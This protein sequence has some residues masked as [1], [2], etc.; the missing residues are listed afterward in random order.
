MSVV[1]V[2]PEQ[3]TDCRPH[4]THRKQGRA[5]MSVLTGPG[6]HEPCSGVRVDRLPRRVGE[7]SR[8]QHRARTPVPT[9][10]AQ[11]AWLLMGRSRQGTVVTLHMNPS[12]PAFL[13]R[14]EAKGHALPT[15]SAKMSLLLATTAWAA[16]AGRDFFS[17]IARRRDGI[18]ALLQ[19]PRRRL[20][21][22]GLHHRW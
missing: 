17:L 14:G 1:A 22:G 5:R 21:P 16:C 18:P 3:P 6:W 19:V 7:P 2:L 13:P 11:A 4:P 12:P 15:K 20:R 10:P 8:N 9:L